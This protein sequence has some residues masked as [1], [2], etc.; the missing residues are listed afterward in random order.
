M[1]ITAITGNITADP[2]VKFIDSGAA[3][4]NFCV[5]VKRPFKRDVT[6]FYYVVAWR[7]AA[8]TIGQYVKKGDMVELVGFMICEEYESNGEK[9]RQWKLNVDRFSFGSSKASRNS[10]ADGSN[11]TQGGSC[12]QNNSNTQGDNNNVPTGNSGDEMPF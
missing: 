10:T 3:V 8:E 9:K 12:Q 2:E 7:Q 1:T 6:D 5:A 11:D 4:C